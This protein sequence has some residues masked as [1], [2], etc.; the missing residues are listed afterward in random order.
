MRPL[1]LAPSSSL[2]GLQLQPSTPY[3]NQSIANQEATESSGEQMNEGQRER[4]TALLT[5]SPDCLFQWAKTVPSSHPW[6]QAPPRTFVAQ[7][8]AMPCSSTIV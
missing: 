8:A 4:L 3:P 6:S 2:S 5:H 1:N 7:V